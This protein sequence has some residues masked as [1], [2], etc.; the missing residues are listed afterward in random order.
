MT[1]KRGETDA[2]GQSGVI[3][4]EVISGGGREG[5]AESDGGGGGSI[6]LN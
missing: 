6:L 2:E 1:F 3:F 5:K 4:D